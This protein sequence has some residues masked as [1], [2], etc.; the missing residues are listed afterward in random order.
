MQAEMVGRATYYHLP[1][2]VMRNGE[3]Y[4]PYAPTC[5]VDASLWPLMGGE[6]VIVTIPG[7]PDVALRVTDTGYLRRWGV[8]IDVPMGTYQRYFGGAT[9]A[10][11][12]LLQ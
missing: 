4:D 3:M 6:I 11:V 2:N 8:V 9:T 7:Q 1:G 12:R 10:T 5:A